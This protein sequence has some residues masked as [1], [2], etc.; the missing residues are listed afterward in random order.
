MTP[1][2]K[3]DRY[4]LPKDT[5][6]LSARKRAFALFSQGYRP[7]R[8]RRELGI[9][10]TTAYHYFT[11]YKKLPANAG[12]A[13]QNLQKSKARNP[14]FIAGI[15]K[16]LASFLSVP[17]KVVI[18]ELQ[19]PWALQRIATGKFMEQA[20]KTQMEKLANALKFIELYEVVGV[21]IEK[22]T[23]ALD[24]LEKEASQQ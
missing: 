7:A 9:K 1:R 12:R 4:P 2:K 15:A 22:I 11:A 3:V 16:G 19:K 18:E 23:A 5:D 17:E 14:A 8:V 21:P 13:Y 24:K 6:G 20:N 10:P